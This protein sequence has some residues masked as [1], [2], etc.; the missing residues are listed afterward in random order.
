MIRGLIFGIIRILAWVIL[1]YLMLTVVRTIAA[2][3]RS[4]SRR[5]DQ[6]PS[7][8][9]SEPPRK[10]VEEYHD[11]HDATFKEEKEEKEE[12]K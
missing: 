5:N 9:A 1:F 4:W 10:P 7:T 6:R 11:V 2:A 3:F 12:K 8:I